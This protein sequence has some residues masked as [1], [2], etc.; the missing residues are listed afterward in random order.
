MSQSRTHL[1]YKQ[2]R[3]SSHPISTHPEF[4][5]RPLHGA[6]H[7]GV[8]RPKQKAEESSTAASLGKTHKSFRNWTW[9]AR[10]LLDDVGT[11]GVHRP[12]CHRQHARRRNDGRQPYVLCMELAV[13]SGETPSPYPLS[14]RRLVWKRRNSSGTKGHGIKLRAGIGL[15]GHMEGQ[16]WIGWLGR[17]C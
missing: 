16:A 2:L 7:L 12:R 15:V 6:G 5:H 17:C 10:S 13:S 1:L 8:S 3:K 11:C 9:G 14:Y 4:P